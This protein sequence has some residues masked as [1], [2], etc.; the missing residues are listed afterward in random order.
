MNMGSQDI[1]VNSHIRSNFRAFSDQN[2]CLGPGDCGF[3]DTNAGVAI[4]ERFELESNGLINGFGGQKRVMT[5][6]E[7]IPKDF[8]KQPEGT[9]ENGKSAFKFGNTCSCKEHRQLCSAEVPPPSIPIHRGGLQ[10][11]G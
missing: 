7:K 6:N 5:R 9:H 3:D 11:G 8:V 10:E 1:E 4:A 2:D